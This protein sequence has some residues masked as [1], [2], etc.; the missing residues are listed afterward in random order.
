MLK[1]N[2]TSKKIELKELSLEEWYQLGP[3][4]HAICFG[5]DN[6]SPFKDRFDYAILAVY[7]E[8]PIAFLT[9]RET[10]AD[11]IYMQYCG[12]FPP[13]EKSPKVLACLLKFIEW[14]HISGYSHINGLVEN[15]NKSMLKLC[16]ALDFIVVG[17]RTHGQSVLLDLYFDLNNWEDS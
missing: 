15:T 1:N 5:A 8:T 10:S 16:I 6:H 13:I 12:V 7:N 2:M 17:T 11:G 9:A 3:K 14:A 4:A